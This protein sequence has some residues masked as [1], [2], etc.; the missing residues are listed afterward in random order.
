MPIVILGHY[1]K[2]FRFSSIYRAR[3]ECKSKNSLK[4][5]LLLLLNARH[6]PRVEVVRHVMDVRS[7]VMVPTIIRRCLNYNYNNRHPRMLLMKLHV[8]TFV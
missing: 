7:H 1:N 4:K 6:L 8:Y 3:T 2:I 5:L